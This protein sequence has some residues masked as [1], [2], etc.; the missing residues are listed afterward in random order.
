MERREQ[1]IEI[2]NAKFED[3]ERLCEIY[4]E[5]FSETSPMTKHWWG[6]MENPNII[7][8][9]AIFAKFIQKLL[10]KLHR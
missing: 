10:V 2:C 9:V 8:R 6:I 7:Y 3:L 4:S 1:Q 5:A